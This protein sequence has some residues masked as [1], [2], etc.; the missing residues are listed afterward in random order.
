MLIRLIT[1]PAK[2][3][4]TDHIGVTAAAG[5]YFGKVVHM[6]IVTHSVTPTID[7]SQ[8]GLKSYTIH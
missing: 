6:I 1:Y 2:M 4:N 3:V 7:K 8:E 5:T